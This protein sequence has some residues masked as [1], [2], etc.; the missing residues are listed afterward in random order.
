[1]TNAN[2]S[3][4]LASDGFSYPRSRTLDAHSPH[5]LRESNKSGK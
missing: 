2:G 1:M 5:I 4:T 3:Q